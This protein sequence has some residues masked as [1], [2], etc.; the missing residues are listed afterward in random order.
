MLQSSMGKQRYVNIF[1]VAVSLA[2]FL[3]SACWLACLSV[4]LPTYLP[5]YIFF[6]PFIHLLLLSVYMSL[7]LCISFL[8]TACLPAFNTWKQ[9]QFAFAAA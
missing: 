6:R 5:T 2:V 4:C 8:C 7:F 1:C 9:H 3:A